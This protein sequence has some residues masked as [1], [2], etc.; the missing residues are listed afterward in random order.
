MD[1][2]TISHSVAA[3][4]REMRRFR[5]SPR[6]CRTNNTP[7][8]P[9]GRK[10]HNAIKNNDHHPN[11]NNNNC[12]GRKKARNQIESPVLLFLLL[13]LLLLLIFLLLSAILSNR[14]EIRRKNLA[15][16]GNCLLSGIAAPLGPFIVILFLF[17]FLYSR[18]LNS[19]EC[20]SA[21]PSADDN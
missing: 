13:L 10:Q 20:N 6:R 3:P 17:F 16:S 8:K 12:N 19:T 18:H 4:E 1:G 7:R 5:L 21:Y 2:R 9:H 14:K 11:N 15:A